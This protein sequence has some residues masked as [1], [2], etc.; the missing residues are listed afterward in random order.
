MARVRQALQYVPATRLTL[1]P[2]FGFA[3]SGTNPV[4]LEEA[5]GKLKV[6]A[7]AARQLRAAANVPQTP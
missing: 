2:D 5:Y 1:N 4:P 6:L 3:P 7:E